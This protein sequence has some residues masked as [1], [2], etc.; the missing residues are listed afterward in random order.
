VARRMAALAVV[1][2]AV[3]ECWKIGRG[4]PLSREALQAAGVSDVFIDRLTDLARELDWNGSRLVDALEARA[5]E[6]V[7]G[8]RAAARD[9]VRDALTDEGYLDVRQPL[10]EDEARAQ[11]LSEACDVVQQGDIDDDEVAAVFDRFWSSLI[12]RETGSRE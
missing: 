2:Q 12:G 3:C 7:R 8:F 11:V 5:D 10:T 9:S 4:R 1:I 6:R